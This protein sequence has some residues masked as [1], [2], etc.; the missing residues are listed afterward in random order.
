MLQ[1]IS[2]FVCR[3]I[4]SAF[5]H[6]LF[7]LWT[8]V[9]FLQHDLCLPFF[10]QTFTGAMSSITFLNFELNE[11]RRRSTESAEMLWVKDIAFINTAVVFSSMYLFLTETDLDSVVIE[12]NI[13]KKIQKWSDNAT[14]L[15]TMDAM[16]R[17]L[18][19]S[20]SRVC[21]RLCVS[22]CT[23]WIKS[24]VFRTVTIYFVVVSLHVDG[25]WW[26]SCMAWEGL[27]ISIMW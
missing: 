24:K 2:S 7:I 14:S 6:C 5:L 1:W 8:A 27:R 22:P 19:M 15:I 23:C 18:L 11:S 9:D 20:K 3:Y 12:I 16:F 26:V 25:I 4:R 10:L 13:P 17:P 21:P